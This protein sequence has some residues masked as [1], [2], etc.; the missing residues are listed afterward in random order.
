MAGLSSLSLLHRSLAQQ[1][2]RHHN[3]KLAQQ[4]IQSIDDP[5]LAGPA[6]YVKQLEAKANDRNRRIVHEIPDSKVEQPQLQ[7]QAIAD[8]NKIGYE[9]AEELLRNKIINNPRNIYL[10]SA[11]EGLDKHGKA[12]LNRL[13]KPRTLE[14]AMIYEQRK[15]LNPALVRKEGDSTS[16][17]E[18]NLD[19][20]ES[21]R[22]DNPS[23]FDSGRDAV[24]GDPHIF[25]YTSR[26]VL[27]DT[28]KPAH[29]G[30]ALTHP[31]KIVIDN[32]GR[33]M[34]IVNPGI[35]NRVK[36]LLAARSLERA[37]SQ[38]WKGSNV[39]Q[40]ELF[41]DSFRLAAGDLPENTQSLKGLSNKEIEELAFE[42]KF[43]GQ[44]LSKAGP[45]QLPFPHKIAD[46]QLKA[47][48]RKAAIYRG[49]P[50][51]MPQGNKET[52]IPPKPDL[53]RHEMTS[54]ERQLMDEANLSADERVSKSG[55]NRPETEMDR[56]SK[57]N[58]DRIQK[59]EE[60]V[61]T[62][63][64]DYANVGME[65]SKAGM[66]KTDNQLVDLGL[67][68]PNEQKLIMDEA[69]KQLKFVKDAS[70]N[71]VPQTAIA[72]KVQEEIKTFGKAQNANAFVQDVYGR[73]D[74]MFPGF[75]KN[76]PDSK[77]FF[78]LVESGPNKGEAIPRG[79][80]GGKLRGGKNASMA[81]RLV[82]D[83]QNLS[84]WAKTIRNPKTSPEKR[85]ASVKEVLALD[86][87]YHGTN[88]TMADV[89]QEYRGG[90]R[91]TAAVDIGEKSKS[92][93][94]REGVDDDLGRPSEDVNLDYHEGETVK[95][96]PRRTDAGVE[97]AGT[98][99]RKAS[100]QRLKKLTEELEKRPTQ[101]EISKMTKTDAPH[102]AHIADITNKLVLE[103]QKL[104]KT[105]HRQQE[106]KYGHDLGP[107]SSS[108]LEALK[109]KQSGFD[110][111]NIGAPP[112]QSPLE[113][114]I[115]QI[116]M[117]VGK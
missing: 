21:D 19:K 28:L 112:T 12:T 111:K 38:T 89:A 97:F 43:G 86:N 34:E 51:Y 117:N 71:K 107:K 69:A 104:K 61:A 103:I 83:R 53:I 9:I 74:Q 4:A 32:R 93:Q 63:G 115:Q 79:A 42:Q 37:R 99:D 16:T 92:G 90:E 15:K 47:N 13:V 98:L 57:L 94:R 102:A 87:K 95:L 44:S 26:G 52:G 105:M 77:F 91:G 113:S 48:K 20:T 31:E 36:A 75:R 109:R 14:E 68:I 29:P 70:L 18:R 8:P 66:T 30:K 114:E 7:G 27:E 1:A 17:N 50:K 116:L 33:Q 23:D 54:Q 39:G 76:T 46:D 6:A 45:S 81:S 100:V 72:K 35:E 64:D 49:D 24:K 106:M 73:L 59:V 80:E 108:V 40:G 41:D 2:L 56:V 110:P 82:Q 55:R 60:G 85:V 22:F 67:K 3:K 88:R 11:N 58:R 78:E 10:Q 101:A 5:M 65:A 96:D 25:D 84:G 62:L